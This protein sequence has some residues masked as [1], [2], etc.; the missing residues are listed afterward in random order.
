ML[1]LLLLLLELIDGFCERYTLRT[2]I[3]GK[4]ARVTALVWPMERFDVGVTG[5]RGHKL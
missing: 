3:N 2:G 1:L 5:H 4:Q